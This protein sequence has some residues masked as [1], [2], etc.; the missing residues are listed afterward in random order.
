[1][2]T[3]EEIYDVIPKPVLQKIINR[4]ELDINGGIH[5]IDHWSRVLINAL[6][7]AEKNNANKK[8]LI[9][10][11]FFHDIRREHES[12]DPEHGLRGAKYLQTFKYKININKNELKK[13]MIA[14]EGHTSVLHHED[15]DIATCWD[16]DRLDLYRVGVKPDP[17][18]LN[19]EF[20]KNAINI[21][22]A[23]ARSWF[24]REEWVIDL[25]NDLKK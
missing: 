10:F 20:A 17:E 18:Y 13:A 24:N 4:F 15:I 22:H 19:T 3:K 12:G 6:K 8:I 5:G 14:C 2:I 25:F 9:V 7:I 11:S 16:A 21:S 1:M 23:T